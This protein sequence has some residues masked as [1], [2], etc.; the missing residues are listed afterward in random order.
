MV[1]IILKPLF[2]FLY[3][4]NGK[5]EF[6]VRIT[7]QEKIKKFRLSSIALMVTMT[8]LLQKGEN[9]V[10]FVMM[11]FLSGRSMSTKLECEDFN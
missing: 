1:A 9:Q 2:L 3:S 10:F 11:T 8:T 7:H 5:I 4:V 6:S